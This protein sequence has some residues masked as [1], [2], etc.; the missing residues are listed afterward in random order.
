M[1]PFEV[2]YISLEFQKY[3]IRPVGG[4]SEKRTNQNIEKM[5]ENVRGVL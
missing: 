2:S 5:L 1:I 3:E 4:L